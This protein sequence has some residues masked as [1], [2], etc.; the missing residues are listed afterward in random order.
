MTETASWVGSL[1]NA[2]ALSG[3]VVIIYVM[4][5]VEN[6]RIGRIDPYF[7]RQLRRFA[8]TVTSLAL[9]YSVISDDWH[10]SLPVLFLVSAGVINMIVNAVSLHLRSPTN[11]GSRARVH[12]APHFMAKLVRYFHLHR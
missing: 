5:M 9:C 2:V 3:V 8:F 1:Y 11:P 7:V 12:S 6:D 10:R 4:Q